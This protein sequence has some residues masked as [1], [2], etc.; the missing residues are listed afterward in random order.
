[1]SVTGSLAQV[2]EVVIRK[3]E[4]LLKRTKTNGRDG[5]GQTFFVKNKTKTGLY[6]ILHQ[7]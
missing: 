6:S 5:E 1:M 3:I 2:P 4:S 7:I